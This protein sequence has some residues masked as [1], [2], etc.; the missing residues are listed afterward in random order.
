MLNS[1]SR[2]TTGSKN[3][4]N[5]VYLRAVSH[6]TKNYISPCKTAKISVKHSLLCTVVCILKTD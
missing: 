1:T 6:E 4:Q 5:D 3:L 2:I